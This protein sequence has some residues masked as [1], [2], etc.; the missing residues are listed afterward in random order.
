MK[1]IIHR[2]VEFTPDDVKDALMEALRNADQAYPDGKHTTFKYELG[3]DGATLS[4]EE[5]H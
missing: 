2:R 1:K 4:W 3:V 5:V